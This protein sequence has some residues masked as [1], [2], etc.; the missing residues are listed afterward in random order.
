MKKIIKIATLFL[1]LFVLSNCSLNQIK[2]EAP[3]VN[4]IKLS[5]KFKINLPEE[6][7]SGYIWQLNDNYN[8]TILTNINTVWLGDKKGIDF[9]FEALSVGEVTLTLI[10][11]K[12]VDTIE[13]KTFIVKILE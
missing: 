11:R 12:Y 4:A 7:K 10:K 3:L 1:L 8:K 13:N 5:K 2:N 6:Y 9:N